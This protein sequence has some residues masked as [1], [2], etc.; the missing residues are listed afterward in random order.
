MF[1]DG[2][3]PLALDPGLPLPPPD[4]EPVEHVAAMLTGLIRAGAGT[5][6]IDPP[7]IPGWMPM[8]TVDEGELA[9]T[10]QNEVIVATFAADES[11]VPEAARTMWQL[12]QSQGR[13][14]AD[15]LFISVSR[16]ETS[17]GRRSG[18]PVTA[19]RTGFRTGP[20]HHSA[21]PRARRPA[22][23]GSRRRA[24]GS[25]PPGASRRS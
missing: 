4:A 3:R 16:R 9:V 19:D 1:I 23:R 10:G 15:P 8:A 17:R 22:P 21:R 7:S 24:C 12:A 13:T 20:T 25:P 2:E 11:S 6:W 5:G 14:E 18:A